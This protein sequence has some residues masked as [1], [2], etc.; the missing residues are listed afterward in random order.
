M[1]LVFNLIVSQAVVAPTFNPSTGDAERGQPALQSKVQDSQ[2]YTERP[3]L[4]KR[5]KKKLITCGLMW[6]A[7]VLAL[8]RQR[9]V[10]LR[11]SEVSWVYTVNSQQ[12]RT[13]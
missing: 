12:G 2:G 3:C 13:V 7:P 8:G 1:V 11:K 4:E 5:G 6:I 9:R 10:G